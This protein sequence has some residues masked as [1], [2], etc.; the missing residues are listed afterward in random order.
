[1]HESTRGHE[2][3]EHTADMGLRG[4]GPDEKSAICEAAT[5]LFELMRGDETPQ[6]DM[7]FDLEVEGHS[8]EELLVELL[9]ET[10]SLS[11]LNETSPVDIEGAT[12][13]PRGAGFIMRVKMRASGWTGPGERKGSEVK[14][15]VGY[16]ADVRRRSD[17]TWEASCVV[18]V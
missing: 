17:G 8:L 9:N 5:A 10:I 7:A 16:G 18:D 6:P 13:E 1:M 2:T 11:D 3:F 14:A 12:L 4:W 15:A